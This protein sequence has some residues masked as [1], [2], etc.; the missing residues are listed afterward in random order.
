M[1][2]KQVCDIL[3]IKPYVEPKRAKQIILVSNDAMSLFRQAKE[4]IEQ[5]HNREFEILTAS[6]TI[7]KYEGH[8]AVSR[9]RFIDSSSPES[10]RGCTID[11][12]YVDT[13]VKKDLDTIKSCLYPCA[14]QI[15]E[16]D[17][18]EDT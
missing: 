2:H 8:N 10:L 11:V 6:M 15:I 12:L 5:N 16:L 7:I 9:T 17:K 18:Q 3:G 13:F 4:S 1:K 14:K